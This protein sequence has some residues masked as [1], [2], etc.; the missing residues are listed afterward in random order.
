[1]QT[2]ILKDM[3]TRHSYLTGNLAIPLCLILQFS[4]VMFCIISTLYSHRANYIYSKITYTA[5][6]AESL[7]GIRY[8]KQNEDQIM[9]SNPI[10][11]PTIENFQAISPIQ[12]NSLTFRLLKTPEYIFSF[13]QS[14]N[15]TC[16]LKA[17]YKNSNEE[18]HI[19]NI[20][21][22]FP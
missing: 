8:F 3:D 14:N 17:N 18:T 2:N 22:Y 16:I 6:Y 21:L 11:S 4:L 13:S 19:S 20:N 10:Q 7:S 1:M 15:T 5:N 12:F 9:L